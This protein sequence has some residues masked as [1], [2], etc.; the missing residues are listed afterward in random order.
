MKSGNEDFW[1]FFL[2][3]VQRVPKEGERIP[4]PRETVPC[5]CGAT[6][7]KPLFLVLD[8]HNFQ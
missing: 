5:S 2:K 4:L 8:D 3:S 1:E 7:E 6:S